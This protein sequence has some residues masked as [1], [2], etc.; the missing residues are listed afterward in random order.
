[1]DGANIPPPDAYVDAVFGERG[2]LAAKWPSYRPRAGQLALA[3]AVDRAIVG[4]RALV[5]EA[6]T[7]VGKSMGYSVPASYHASQSGLQAVICTANI[8]LQEQLVSKDLPLLQSLVPW[9][10]SF[11]LFKG[12]SNFLCLDRQKKDAAMR[13]LFSQGATPPDGV[14]PK[15]LQIVRDWAQD[16]ANDPKHNSGDVSEL[17]F[18]PDQNLWRMFST[19]SSGCK[20]KT[21]KWKKECFANQAFYRAQ[22]ADVIVTNQHM[23]AAHLQFYLNSGMDAVLP[24]FSVCIVDEAHKLPDIVRDFFGF[25]LTEGGITRLVKKVREPKIADELHRAKVYFFQAL[26]ELKADPIRYKARLT[27]FTPLHPE[28]KPWAALETAMVNAIDDMSGPQHRDLRERAKPYMTEDLSEPLSSAYSSASAMECIEA[29]QESLKST[30]KAREVLSN[31]VSA[32]GTTIALDDVFDIPAPDVPDL[33]YFLEENEKGQI[34][35]GSKVIRPGGIL[36]KGLF[37]KVRVPRDEDDEIGPR[38]VSVIATSATLS[39]DGGNFGFAL[40]ELGANGPETDTLVCESPFDWAT[41]CLF[42]VPKTMPP[43]SPIKTFNLAAGEHVERIIG[44]ADGRTL[45]LFTSRNGL[46]QAYDRVFG[47]CRD[48]GI[49]LLR[50]GDAPRTQLV[51]RFKEDIRSVLLGTESFWAG[52]DVPGEACSVVVID[53]LPFAPPDD[54][55]AN[56][57]QEAEGNSFFRYSLPKAILQL[58][59]GFGRL[60]R[61]LD[62]HGVVVCLDRRIVT[63]AYGKRVLKALPFEVPK[64]EQLDSIVEWLRGH[65]TGAPVQPRPV[66]Q[67]LLYDTQ[68]GDEIPFAVPVDVQPRHLR[69]QTRWEKW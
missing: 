67:A 19:D 12:R 26:R 28:H 54:A 25:K 18:E 7:G 45:G 17:P 15:R 66:T 48:N 59:Q 68:D 4:K 13:D 49:T 2:Y 31:L 51:T 40:E 11:A 32:F 27:K 50:Q 30:E 65:T 61:S 23:L 39:T 14:D 35:I 62:C 64:S 22:E 37:D 9:R 42:I 33:V 47:F 5:A 38:K 53:R 3:H 57:I 43:P 58:K 36:H 16:S 60:V 34:S 55:V 29:Y 10:F 6:G 1:M 8:A 20:K 69:R 63:Q 52:V 44:L 46:N 41:Q 56:A 21:C 24:P